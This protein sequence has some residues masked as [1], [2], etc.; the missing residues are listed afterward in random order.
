MIVLAARQA[1]PAWPLCLPLSRGTPKYGK[2]GT[3]DVFSVGREDS[4]IGF[5]C[6]GQELSEVA[7]AFFT[8]SLVFTWDTLGTHA[9]VFIH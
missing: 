8:F 1:R 6:M 9:N 7:T 5:L 3:R 2:T 4:H